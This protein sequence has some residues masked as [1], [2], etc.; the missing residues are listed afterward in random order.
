VP[1]SH[2]GGLQ[3]VFVHHQVR[4]MSSVH[5]M[6][7]NGAPCSNGLFFAFSFLAEPKLQAFDEL[8]RTL[9]TDLTDKITL[10]ED[11]PHG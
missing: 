5:T 1:V 2:G 8:L 6:S 10:S 11:V 4:K 9:I 7:K 3:A